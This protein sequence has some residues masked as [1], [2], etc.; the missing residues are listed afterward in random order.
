[1]TPSP[2]TT[3][4]QSWVS[5]LIRNLP[6]ACLLIL[7]FAALASV[8]ARIVGH[9][10]W[11]LL[12]IGAGLF[13][14][15]VLAARR[16]VPRGMIPAR[17]KLA[18]EG[19][20][21]GWCLSLTALGL[22]LRVLWIVIVPAIQASDFQ[23]YVSLADRLMQTGEYWTMTAGGERWYAYRAPGYST[24]L[25]AWMLVLGNQPWLPGVLNAGL[26]VLTA[27]TLRKLAIEYGGGLSATATVG[28]Y[29][30]WPTNI[31]STGLAGY[32]P[33]LSWMILLSIRS[34]GAS[35]KKNQVRWALAAGLVTG[36]SAL[37]RPTTIMARP[38]L[39]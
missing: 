23:E 4:R 11:K 13:G 32:E 7:C 25:A 27:G 38:T 34:M 21:M 20:W 22:I 15:A 1:M 29:A 37:V 3:E 12:T 2:R 10:W 8:P 31:A 19:H 5:L 9:S 33:L 35:I 16:R 36:L 26:Y 14:V 17:L 39:A 18:I 6:W 30:L 24:F 28:L